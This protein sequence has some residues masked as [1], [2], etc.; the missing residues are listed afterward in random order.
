MLSKRIL[1]IEKLTFFLLL[2]LSV[3][4]FVFFE[5]SGLL[6]ALVIILAVI[7]ALSIV[8]ITESSERVPTRVEAVGL[9]ILYL[10]ILS[11]YNYLFSSSLPLVLVMLAI[12]CLVSLTFYL[13]ITFYRSREMIDR[14]NTE[15]YIGLISLVTLEVFLSLYFWPIAPDL[16]SL[17]IVV[18]FYL[19]IHLVYLSL[20]NMLRLRKTVGYLLTTLLVL[21]IIVYISWPQMA[22]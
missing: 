13:L 9:F 8:F 4:G 6:R 21:S 11:I 1:L 20:Q 14:K 10:S 3:W 2:G 22:K 19:L 12:L 16:K 7:A 5:E 18:I 17:I 15:F